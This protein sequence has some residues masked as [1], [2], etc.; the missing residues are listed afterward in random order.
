M[1]RNQ[2]DKA[3]QAWDYSTAIVLYQQILTRHASDVEIKAKLADCY[4]LVNDPTQAERWYAEVVLDSTS[5]PINKLYY[6]MMLQANGKCNEAKPWFAE[7]SRLKPNDERGRAL[8]QSCDQQELL[9]T[10]SR[11]SYV[12]AHLPI[13]SNMDDFGPAVLGNRLVFASDRDPG[14]PIKRVNAWTG[15]PFCELYAVPFYR[16]ST[17]FGSF[18]WGRAERFSRSINSK[19]HE[20]SVTF[21]ADTQTIY[22]TRNNYL[23]G[24]TGHSDEGL[25]KLKIYSGTLSGTDTWENLQ[26]L[27]FCSDEYSTA[28]PS[29]SADGKRLFFASNKPGG[30]GG[31]DIYV[32]HWENDRWG[33]PINLGPEV[34]TAGNEVFPHISPDNRLYFAS[35]SQVGLGG[36]DIYFTTPKGRTAWN[37]PVN[38]GAP[39]NSNR[40]DFGLVFASAGGD[41]GFFSSDR[42][43]GAGRDDLYAFQ[44]GAATV[45]VVVSNAFNKKPLA[46]VTLQDR[47]SGLTMN[48]GPDGRIVFDMPLNECTDFALSRKDFEPGQGKA[49]TKGLPNGGTVRVELSLQRITNNHLVGLVFDMLDGLPAE[50][51]LVTLTNDCNKPEQTFT[52]GSDGRYRFKLSKGCCYKVRAVGEGYIADAV[53]GNCT[54]D[55]GPDE[56]IRA[57]LSLQPYRDAEGFVV[58]TAQRDDMPLYNPVSGLYETP[59]GQPASADFGDG[60]VIRKGVMFDNGTL[61]MPAREGWTR[62]RDGDGFLVNLY[63]DYDQSDFRAESLSDLEKLFSMLRDNPELQVEIASH[64]D[65]RGSAEYNASLSQRRADTVVNWLVGKGIARERL[66]ARGYGESSPVAPCVNCSE[67]EHQLNR[68]TEFKVLG[69]VAVD[70]KAPCQGCPF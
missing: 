65:N 16:D 34:N 23:Q 7:Y 20:A 3:M 6:G 44:K 42:D 4:R 55:I 59:D 2:A 51:V 37:L 62:D 35:N 21:S 38:L 67:R 17:Q 32:S 49:C 40:D 19:F 56:D 43:G 10:K 18:G 69:K 9:L 70:K 11:S 50:G 25:V 12:V 46:G 39:I 28:H 61:S 63:Y 53:E 68:R 5:A 13:N 1:L 8:A 52:T 36:L 64:T 27:P 47:R 45:E 57:D 33:L 15:A 66:T 26:A 22:F 30:Y 48:S 58:K 29:L 14:G 54:L 41:W 60:L 24:K 31:M